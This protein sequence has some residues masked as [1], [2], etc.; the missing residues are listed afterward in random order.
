M[1]DNRDNEIKI[2]VG[3]SDAFQCVQVGVKK[4]FVRHLGARDKYRDKYLRKQ[5]G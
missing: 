2:A 5:P 4:C 1:P 3:G